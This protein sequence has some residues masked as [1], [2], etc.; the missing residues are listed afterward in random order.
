[1]SMTLYWGVYLENVLR[2]NEQAQ[3]PF[4]VGIYFYFIFFILNWK[5]KYSLL[6]WDHSIDI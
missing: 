6:N 5:Y 2:I 4:P 1:M 3:N